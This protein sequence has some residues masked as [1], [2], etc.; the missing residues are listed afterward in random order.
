MF[1]PLTWVRTNPVGFEGAD[2]TSTYVIM[3]EHV[4]FAYRTQKTQDKGVIAQLF[5]FYYALNNWT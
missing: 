1:P 5:H 3:A 4:L 2:C